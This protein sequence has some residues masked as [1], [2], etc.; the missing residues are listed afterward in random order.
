MNKDLIEDIYSLSPMQ[1]GMLFHQLAQPDSEAY[2]EQVSCEFEGE[3]KLQ[4]FK[5]A[6]QEIVNRYPV[7]RTSF[8]WDGLDK[9]VQVVLKTATLPW[10][11]LDWSG[12]DQTKIAEKFELLLRDDRRKGFNHEQAPLMRCMLVRTTEKSWKFIWS[13]HHMLMDGW[14]SG[15][16]LDELF[17]RYEALV[18]HKS[19]QFQATPPFKNYISWLGKQ[20]HKKAGEFWS[21]EL[22]GFD[23]P[24]S[25]GIGDAILVDKNHVSHGYAEYT[26][27]LS[28]KLSKEI[29][30]WT[31]HAGITTNILIQGAWSILL[32]TYSGENEVVFGATVSGRPPELQN[33]ES[34]VGLFINSLPVKVNI[35]RNTDIVTW[36]KDLQNKNNERNEFSFTPLVDIKKASDVSGDMPLFR[37]LLVFE[38]YP[39]DAAAQQGFHGLEIKNVKSFEETNYPLTLM[40]IPRGP[41]LRFQMNY[42]KDSFEQKE[43]EKLFSHLETAIRSILNNPQ[44]VPAR[45]SILS[46]TER[47]EVLIRFNNTSTAIPS[48]QTVLDLINNRIKE[49]PDSIAIVCGD[50]SISYQ[51]LDHQANVMRYVLL[52]KGLAKSDI[53]AVLQ[54]RSIDLIVSILGIMKAGAAFLPI[55]TSLPHQRIHSLIKDARVKI[56]IS[57]NSDLVEEV[58]KGSLIVIDPKIINN[59]IITLQQGLKNIAPNPEDLAYIIYTSGSTGKPKGVKINHLSLLNYIVWADDYYFTQNP[60]GGDFPLFTSPAFDLTLSSIFIPLSKGKTIKIY[61][62]TEI[63]LIMEDVFGPEGTLDTVKLTPS[64]ITLLKDIPEGNNKLHTLIAGGEALKEEHMQIVNDKWPGV[65]IFN[66]YGPTEATIGCTATAVS[67]GNINAGKPVANTSIYI[68]NEAMMPIPTGIKGEIYIGGTCLAEGY[69]RQP[70]QTALRFIDSPFE[71]GKKIYRTGDIGCWLEDGNIQYFGRGDDQVKVRGYRIE[72]GEI[73]SHINKYPGV[74]DVVVLPVKNSSQETNLVAFVKVAELSSFKLEDL[75]KTV[76]RHLP[77]YMLPAQYQVVDDFPLTSNGK[78]NKKA[79]LNGLKVIAAT[80]TKYSAPGKPVQEI[81]AAIWAEIL[82][83]Q[84]PGIFDNFFEL[85]GH[86]LNATQMTSRIRG[87]FKVNIGVKEVLENPTIDQL[88]SL[89]EKLKGSVIENDFPPIVRVTGKERSQLSFAQQRLWFLDRLE[90]QSASYNIPEAIK[91]DGR[92]DKKALQNAFT[93]IIN[94]HEI[95]RTNFHDVDGKAYQLVKEA[96]PFIIPVIVAENDTLEGLIAN[97]A[98]KP[99]DLEHDSLIRA[100]LFKIAEDE[101]VLSVNMHHI[102][103]DGWSSGVFIGELIALYQSFSSGEPSS[104]P[105]LPIQYSDFSSWQR[106]L[107]NKHF[108][109]PQLAYWKNKLSGAPFILDLPT[110]KPRPAIRTE[111]G[112]AHR[113]ALSAELST[114][115]RNLSNKQGA[116]LFMTLLSA[117]SL[118]L[119]RYGRQNTLLIGSS[120]ANRNRKETEALIGF[121]INIIVY[122][123]NLEDADNFLSLIEQVKQLAF[124]AYAHQDIPFDQV[125]EEIQPER[126]MSYSPVFQVAFDMQNMP[127]PAFEIPGLKIAPKDL[128]RPIAKYDLYLSVE[129]TPAGLKAI[130]EYN[131]DLFLHSTVEQMANHFCG[132]LEKMTEN[133]KQSLKSLPLLNENEYRKI[134]YD[135]NNTDYPLPENKTVLDRIAEIAK[136][137]PGHIAFEYDGSSLTYQQLENEANNFAGY[138]LSKGLRNG[139]RVGVIAIRSIRILS[140]ILGIMKAGGVYVPIDPEYPLDRISFMLLDAEVKFLA[141][142]EN[143]LKGFDLPFINTREAVTY[144]HGGHINRVINPESLAYIIYTSGS[145]GNPKGVMLRHIGLLNLS[146]ELGKGF[147]VGGNSKTLQFASLSFDASIAEIFVCLYA[148]A[149]VV[150]APKAKMLPGPDLISLLENTEISY[151][152]IPP[153]ILKVLPYTKLP[154]LKTLIV[155]GEACQSELVSIWGEGRNFINAYGPTEYTVCASLTLCDTDGGPLNIGKPI[156]NTAIYILDENLLPLPPGIP[157]ELFISGIGIAAGYINLPEINAQRFID[158]PF[159]KK[160]DAKMYRSGDLAK[161]LPDGNICY[162]GRIDRQVKLRGFRIE[163][164]EIEATLKSHPSVMEAVIQVQQDANGHQRLVAF[165]TLYK[166]VINKDQ[167]GLEE[168][169]QDKLPVYLQPNSIITL[170]EIPLTLNGKIDQK[171]LEAYAKGNVR[172]LNE[173]T[174]PRNAQEKKLAEIWESVLGVENAGIHHNFFKLGGDSILSIQIVSRARSAG[175]E[176]TPKDIFENQTIASLAAVAKEKSRTTAEQGPIVG[177]VPL[178]PIQQWFF[179]QEFAFPDHFNQAALLETDQKT[180][181]GII[182]Q[183]LGKLIA[184]HDILRARF[185]KD[186]GNIWIQEI[187]PESPE[188]IFVSYDLSNSQDEEKESQFLEIANE[189]QSKLSLEN[190]KIFKAAFF[191]M[192]DNMPSRLLLIAHHL[193]VD[194]VSWRILLEDFFNL[195]NNPPSSNLPEKTHSFK[196]WINAITRYAKN[197]IS[198]DEIRYWEKISS[199]EI[200]PVPVEEITDFKINS[201]GIVA[202]YLD[203]NS[204]QDLIKVVPAAYRIHIQEVLLSAFVQSLNQWTRSDTAFIEL[205]GHGREE[206]VND[207]DISRTVGWFTSAYPVVFHLSENANSGEVLQS[208]KQQ[209]RAIPNKGIGYGLLRYLSNE[210]ERFS[211][212]QHPQVI[213]NYLGQSDSSITANNGWRFSDTDCGFEQSQNNHRTHLLSVNLIIINGRLK[214]AIEYDKHQHSY[215][216]IDNLSKSF[217]ANLNKLI[218]HCL[219]PGTA[220][221]SAVDFPV[222]ILNEHNLEVLSEQIKENGYS[223]P[224]VADIYPLSPL[225]QGLLFESLL[226]PLS[227]SY[228]EQLSVNIKGKLNARM[229]KKAWQNVINKYDIFRTAFFWDG[230]DAPTQV[231]FNKAD[232]IWSEEVWTNENGEAEKFIESDIQKPFAFSKA[233]LT[234]FK[235]SRLQNDEWFFCWTHHHI[236]MDGWCLPIILREVFDQYEGLQ[237]GIEPHVTHTKPYVNFISWLAKLDETAAR[238]WWVKYLDGF[239]HPT[240]FGID[241]YQSGI[242]E[243][244]RIQECITGLDPELEVALKQFSQNEGIT[245]NILVHAAWSLLL[246]R[247]S[248]TNDVVFG[249]TVSG[250]PPE[251]E[252]VEKMVGLFI[253]SVPV[254][255]RINN[256]EELGKW[257]QGLQSKQLER[258]NYSYTSLTKIREFSGVEGNQPLFESLIIFENYPVDKSVD[259]GIQGLTIGSV[260]FSEQTHYPVTL[261][262]LPGTSLT[263]RISYDSSRFEKET[264]NRLLKHLFSILKGFVAGADQTL[265]Q[266][267]LVD[268][269]ETSLILDTFNS[270]AVIV[271]DVKPVIADFTSYALTHPETTALLFEGENYSYGEINLR[272]N[273]L[274]NYLLSTG[275]KSGELVGLCMDRSPEMVICLLAILKSGAAYLPLDPKFP[276]ERLHY[277]LQDSKA[278]ILLTEEKYRPLWKQEQASIITIEDLQHK[279]VDSSATDPGVEVQPD[280]LVYVIYT[281]GSTGKPK[282][283]QISHGALSNFI[284]SMKLEPGIDKHDVL[285]AVT[286]ISF[287]IAGL[288]IFLPLTSGATLALLQD[289]VASDPLRL[290][291]CLQKIRPTIMQATPT[292]WQMLLNN[293][294]AGSSTLKVLCGGEAL[295]NELAGELVNRTQSVWNMYGPTETTIWSS[296]LQ[297]DPDRHLSANGYAMIGGPIANTQFYIL[298]EL[299]QPTPIG[300]AGE[301][302]IGGDGVANG[303]LGLPALTNEKFIA[304]PFI[305]HPGNRIYRTGDLAKWTHN[306]TISFLG[307]I[308]QQVKIRGFRIETGEIES[309]MK[310]MVGINEAVVIAGKDNQNNDCLLAFMITE[311][312]ENVSSL[313]IREVLQSRLPAYMIPSAFTN[314]DKFPLTPNGK[315]DRK[316]LKDNYKVN[317]SVDDNYI[318]PANQLQEKIHSIWTLVLGLPQIGIKDNFFALGGHSLLATQ[319]ISRVR[320]EFE[321]EFPLK[322]LFDHPDIESFA[323][324]LQLFIN[325][326]KGEQEQVVP[327]DDNEVFEF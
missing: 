292:T 311:Q 13:H 255:V 272:A 80:T 285:L 70:E 201:T 100:I 147:L 230:L 174:A 261:M 140:A 293:G 226:N 119:S 78:T 274:A 217:L 254:R 67:T 123:V 114:K 313:K 170:E 196:E 166:D 42:F 301:L 299:K 161:F 291:S 9:P 103:S 204:T 134:V 224:D 247:Y 29:F 228:R 190:G 36:L 85:G 193:V 47:E 33:V 239:Y 43:I 135:W 314:L 171:A 324:E 234:R 66:E 62:E 246:S 96:Q 37:S 93:E 91:I 199:L 229:F 235:L 104:L 122:R 38:N 297:I 184:H 120:I 231:V 236:L 233:P 117:Y 149:T 186:T 317:V 49:A 86:S 31:K 308:D 290:I 268:Q 223:L 26:H 237:S 232:I 17:K 145:T 14:C 69:I 45:V 252:G 218:N 56:L 141:G 303:Y 225:Q 295:P 257:L 108:F 300:V 95:L 322:K 111:N 164:G 34:I 128:T 321:I 198:S 210:P 253:N 222:S 4:E 264:I 72:P 273:K 1:E 249:A 318:P 176:F 323:A 173:Y 63:G 102:I 168:F 158:D 278:S 267:S 241:H 288:E 265:G 277:M 207:I 138:L 115:L 61:G 7:F 214:I 185:Y 183:A 266:I 101:Y 305:K 21:T 282:G 283:V 209:Y 50:E 52:S 315:T 40:I 143:I 83:I 77:A 142:E 58:E 87:A 121:F 172:T 192:G 259:E 79:L 302:Y 126:D 94:R 88:A 319:C 281:S 181:T 307:R 44:Q 82:K 41:V 81:I 159:S 35:N 39:F 53:V 24:T 220:G 20:D 19:I 326:T 118:L 23:T 263:F 212:K 109:E 25:L 32:G 167:I 73:E 90:G 296:V 227:V 270:K 132:L 55:D 57:Q 256:D 153:S 64:H 106:E 148:G 129:D 238:N 15:I 130:M 2:F 191:T 150:M 320:A 133:P 68:L 200:K 240:P 260:K 215:E 194:G 179:C 84:K 165:V 112:S 309:V 30:E 203:E 137:K 76:Q 245:L 187:M 51:Q 244:D 107:K 243:K 162:I 195:T 169:L 97:E 178:S 287:D 327:D 294:W 188:E 12:L 59:T 157:G 286:T 271:E 3:I 208:I 202:H 316:A 275:L 276:A 46:E 110:D 262:V 298:D 54:E 48:G 156:G 325:E 258:D 99:F 8:H 284:A 131:N 279:I 205:E 11:T 197:D 89:I 151:V 125:I 306:G 146:I 211:M 5:Q 216:T 163:P 144:S 10:E 28:P 71:A 6:W 189:L 113:F 22:A 250:R 152:I 251:L 248:G 180:D 155:A 154:S 289:E 105:S 75:K 127:M 175:L 65:I 206:L 92:L 280:D 60:D 136:E 269:Q 242:S 74:I 310:E 221:I 213:F 139:D 116:T 98:A 182:E 312:G 177:K 124:E 16:I 304:N 18:I 27:D 160:T 219:Q